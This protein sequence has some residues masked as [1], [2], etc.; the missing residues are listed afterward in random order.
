LYRPPLEQAGCRNQRLRYRPAKKAG[1]YFHS[2]FS[3]TLTV[4]PK[5]SPS[6]RN[7]YARLK[8][9]VEGL[10]PLETILLIRKGVPAKILV[11]LSK[12]LQC[13]KQSIYRLAGISR[14]VAERKIL[15]KQ[16][17]SPQST[18]RVFRF[19]RAE[20]KAMEVF[21]IVENAWKWLQAPTVVFQGQ[22]P[23]DLLDTDIGTDEVFK[24][25]AAIEYGGAV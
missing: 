12:Y 8:C 21:G 1:R 10:S 4:M 25:L 9:A 3:F 24:V 6:S 2:D 19:I 11:D 23:I 20:E 16:L 13:P 7:S 17:L 22:A 15:N 5:T 18:E 14:D